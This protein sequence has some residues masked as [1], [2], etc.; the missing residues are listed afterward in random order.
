[1]LMNVLIAIGS[2]AAS[3]AVSVL[4]ADFITGVLHWAEDTWLAPGGNALI[5]K[6]ITEDNIDHHRNPGKIR[7][8]NYWATNRVCIA[9]AA[10][11]AVFF[12]VLQVHAWQV[13]LVLAILSQ[14][15]QIH[16]WGHSS[17]APQWVRFL[18]RYGILQS[19]R[20]HAGHH[21]SP[22]AKRFCSVTEFLNPI[23]DRTRFW[24]ALEST[25]EQFGAK[26]Q[27]ARA[28]RGGY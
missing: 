1:M 16:M 12:L 9:L 17:Q 27:R 11:A 5:D 24:R 26:V 18:Q 7:A 13:Y 6:Y 10:I 22:Y 8:G 25:A 3:I 2:Y 20:H 28:A 15:N 14:S 19:P 23:L 21:K 4:I